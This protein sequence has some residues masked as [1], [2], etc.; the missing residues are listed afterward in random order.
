MKLDLGRA[1]NDATALL[2]AN[3]DVIGIVAGVFFFLPYLALSLLMPEAAQPQINNP[4]DIDA[5]MEALGAIYAENWWIFVLTSVLQMIGM[6]ALFALLTDRARPTVGEALKRGTT[7]FPSYLAAQI[8]VAV[9]I[10]FVGGLL[11][12]ISPFLIILAIPIIFYLLVKFSLIGAVIG[13]E[14]TLNPFAVLKRSWQLTKGNS[15]RIFF[16]FFLIL[17]SL[18]I[19]SLIVTMIFGVVFA[20]AG[21]QIEL[22]GNGI[23]GS[24]VNAIF[25]IIFLG[26]LA[27]L[28]RQLAGPNAEALSET[29]E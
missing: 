22:I 12:V 16:F 26:V 27:S 15:F 5:V 18:M 2:S 13:I 1:W 8:L 9:A 23:V 24:L 19:I 7:G 17:L 25:A 28:H 21:G 29:F 6:L 14:Q 20:A 10:G 3:K 4:E 11:A